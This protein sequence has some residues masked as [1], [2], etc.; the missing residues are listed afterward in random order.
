MELLTKRYAEKIIG[1]LGC[2]DR[3]V[4]KGTLTNL[5]YADGMTRYLKE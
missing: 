2:F 4:V 1:T 5:C 3:I